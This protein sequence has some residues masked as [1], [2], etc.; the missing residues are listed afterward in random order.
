[1]AENARAEWRTELAKSSLYHRH[2]GEADH[3]ETVRILAI[4]GGGI[5]G[6]IPALIL[7]EIEERTGQQACELFDF[8]AGTSTGAILALGAATPGSRRQGQVEGARRRRP[9]RDAWTRDLLQGQVLGRAVP[10]EVPPRVVRARARRSVRRRHAQRGRRPLHGHRVLTPAPP[11][12]P[13]RQRRGEARSQLGLP[14]EDGHPRRH[15]RADVLRAWRVSTRPT[16]PSTC[17]STARCT[18]TTRR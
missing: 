5:R 1:M 13:L 10:R 3:D 7:A 4:D 12:P 2:R 11:G 18:P 15:R 6:I 16:T 14:H 9:L 17:S 8:I